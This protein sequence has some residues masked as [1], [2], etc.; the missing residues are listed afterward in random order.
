MDPRRAEPDRYTSINPVSL[1]GEFTVTGNRKVRCAVSL[2]ECDLII[3]K[4]T[5]A[6]VGRNKVV[7]SLKDCVGCRAY[8]EDDNADP[9]AYLAVYFYPL[10]RRWMSS[11]VSRQRAEQ[12]FRLAA[13]Q[14]PR[15]NL[16][17]AE[18]WAR[19]VR[20]RSAR[21]RYLRDGVLMS[22]LSRPSRMMLLVNPQSGKGHALTLY[23]NHIQRMLNEAGVTHT[24]VITERQN[25]ARELV[26]EADLS[27]WDAL[28]IMSGDGL[29]F[30]VING[31]LERPDWEEA[32]RTPL[33]IL[34]SGSGNAL[35]ASVHHYTGASPVSSEELLVSCGFL[36]CQGLVA[37]MDLV[38]IHLS[39][40]LRLFSFL[41]LAWGFVADVDI[42]SEKYRHVGAAR[43][44]VGTLVRLACLRVYKGKLAYLPATEDY[45]KEEGLGNNMKL[46]CNNQAS[47][48]AAVSRPSRDSPCQNTFHN[49]CHSNNSLKVRRTESTPS[50]SATKPLA[51]PSDSLLLPLDQPLPSNW[52]VVPE[53]DF[54]L[55]LA[56]YQ[57]HLAEDLMAAPDATTDDGVIHLFYVRAGISRTALLRLFLAMEKGAHLST[58][59][60]HLVHTKVRALRLEPYSPKG[61]ITVDGEVVE[62]GPL[63]AEVHRGLGRLIS[64]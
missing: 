35:A 54:V 11:G 50:R 59:C 62:Y 28:V 13:L 53:E 24:L 36:L 42:E 23:N 2:T 3:Q 41:S 12:C 40:G 32:I 31:L 33:G 18:K 21:Q 44:T 58:N 26:K 56:M 20:E 5:S 29:L 6:P 30:E 64:G 17:E 63:Q 8:R 9:A 48:L 4:L 57:S 7:L 34:P 45:S 10:K 49:S 60:Q 25:H 38:S 43:F 22:E 61:I 1:Y 15:A 19:A 27:Q 14:D 46:H 37:H 39:S 47:S 55:M 16:E 51:G 52:V